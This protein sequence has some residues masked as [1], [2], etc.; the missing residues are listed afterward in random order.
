MTF[1]VVLSTQQYCH[2]YSVAVTDTSEFANLEGR[3]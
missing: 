1:P 2:I 3:F